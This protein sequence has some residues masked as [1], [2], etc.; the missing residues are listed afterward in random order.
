MNG[1]KETKTSS[2]VRYR[3]VETP[4]QKEGKTCYAAR[5]VVQNTSLRQI[6]AQMVREGSKYAEHEI[7]G[8]AEQMIDVII[9]RL[10]D[11]HS[12][13]FGSMMRFRPSIKGS[14]DA[15]DEA[16]DPKTHQLVV[17]VS[18]GSRL[19]KALEGVT[20]ECLDEAKLPE[21]REVT[22][23]PLGDLR[24]VEVTGICLRQNNLGDGANW[25]I[26]TADQHYPISSV[27]QKASGRTVTFVLP[28]SAIPRGTE[29]TIV[30]KVGKR[31]FKSSPI[32]L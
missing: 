7:L 20:V 10:R 18:A 24:I 19:R 26:Y 6:A 32:T 14:F 17:A 28:Q 9:D 29:A 15:K 11:G 25:W 16:F 4:M 31:E 21:I 22:V 12:V 3:L 27:V 8:I 1:L 2:K 23:E 30:L 5:A 13:N